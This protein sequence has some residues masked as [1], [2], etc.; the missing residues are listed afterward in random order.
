MLNSFA[1]AA[2]HEFSIFLHN[3]AHNL[4]NVDRSAAS[5]VHAFPPERDVW[6]CGG[7][8]GLL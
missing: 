4:C 2:W 1:K 6:L 3:H 7:V 5:I 8:E